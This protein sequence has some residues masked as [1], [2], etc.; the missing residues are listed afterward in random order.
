MLDSIP[1]WSWVLGTYGL[2]LLI[3]IWFKVDRA[4]P[5]LRDPGPWIR[6]H[7]RSFRRALT[8]RIGNRASVE[9]AVNRIIECTCDRLSVAPGMAHSTGMERDITAR[10]YYLHLGTRPQRP[11]FVII[12]HEI[13]H[14]RLAIDYENSTGID[15]MLRDELGLIPKLR[16][17]C[18]ELEV[19][20]HTDPRLHPFILWFALEAIIVVI[21]TLGPSACKH[22]WRKSKHIARFF[23]RQRRWRGRWW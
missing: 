7:D 16:D 23:A 8:R 11:L 4:E 13:E 3:W 5:I 14:H 2:S 18:I 9:T 10:R 20:W 1:L 21:G 19:R 12:L 15:L 22:L 6:I 17:C